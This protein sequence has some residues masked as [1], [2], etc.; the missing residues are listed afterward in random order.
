MIILLSQY[1][2]LTL[3]NTETSRLVYDCCANLSNERMNRLKMEA[4]EAV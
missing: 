2:K 3:T 4:V 1:L